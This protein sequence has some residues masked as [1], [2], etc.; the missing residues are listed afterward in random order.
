MM[1]CEKRKTKMKPILDEICIEGTTEAFFT[2]KNELHVLLFWIVEM[3]DIYIPY[4]CIGK[5]WM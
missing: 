1:V 5:G 3:D 4:R 2:D